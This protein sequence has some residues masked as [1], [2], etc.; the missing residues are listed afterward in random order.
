MTIGRFSTVAPNS[1]STARTSTSPKPSASACARM[2]VVGMSPSAI[3]SGAASGLRGSRSVVFK[4]CVLAAKRQCYFAGRTV[5]LLA[6]QDFSRSL[7]GRIRLVDFVAID[8]Q[9]H[10]SVLLER[11]AFA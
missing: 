5:A 8:E 4:A 10:V 11:A 6:D 1:C 2:R 9:D 7:V 3:T